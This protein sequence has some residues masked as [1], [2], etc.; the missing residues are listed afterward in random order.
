MD[1]FG[2][3]TLAVLG[4][5]L[6]TGWRYVRSMWANVMSIVIVNTTL[7]DASSDAMLAYAC[8]HWNRSKLGPITYVGWK[9]YVRPERDF[10]SVA[11]ED[12]GKG[13]RLFWD[14]WKP[15]WVSRTAGNS[16]KSDGT[17]FI[18]QPLQITYFRWLF[19]GDEL[20]RKALEYYNKATKDSDTNRFYVM[21]QSGSAGKPVKLASS[22]G[23]E[24][25]DS[26]PKHSYGSLSS[27]ITRRILKWSPSDLGPIT[28]VLEKAVDGMALS[29]SQK[30]HYKRLQRW[31]KSRR[32]FEER[33][34]P[35]KY[36]TLLYGP[37]GTGKSAYVRA[38]AQDL[39]LPVHQFD[40]AT[41]FN[42]ELKERWQL[43]RAN[44]PCIALI[45]DIDAVFEGRK[46]CH[47]DIKLSFDALLNV[48]DGVEQAN[49]LLVFIS[50]N[51]VETLDPALGGEVAGAEA[52]SSR[53]GRIDC[54]VYFGV[55]SEAGRQQIAER[56]LQDWPEK[57]PTVVAGCVGYTGAQF[58]RRC[59]DLA[60][61]LYWTQEEE[62][63]G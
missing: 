19:D 22:P 1:L 20:V 54:S 33:G 51:R 12:I 39:N 49:G 48:L 45:E 27:M 9:T 55:L 34:L 8:K 40:L 61:E 63:D 41:M 24:N 11:A 18:A 59:I 5:A 44:S 23:V 30:A 17:Y 47:D 6:M 53:P 10:M 3:G 16:N 28:S 32:W 52:V 14:G 37:P 29:S 25:V 2:F 56:I 36:G 62:R 7:I 26:I 15:I 4:T 21:Y 60:Q 38:V 50:T 35:W 42:D 31:H 13:S 58:E 57:I 46:P 43:M